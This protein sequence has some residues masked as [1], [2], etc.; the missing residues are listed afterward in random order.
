MGDSPEKPVLLPRQ[1]DIEE[2]REA[3]RETVEL[4]GLSQTKLAKGAGVVQSLVSNILG[5]GKITRETAAKLIE[6]VNELNPQYEW[7]KRPSQGP[8]GF[9]GSTT[10][11]TLRVA[12]VD[13]KFYV[14]P[15]FLTHQEIKSE[16]CPYC[17]AEMYLKC[18]TCGKLIHERLTYCPHEDC[19]APF[20]PVPDD[21]ENLPPAE[22]AR[23]CEVRNRMN[24]QLL[25]HLVEVR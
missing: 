18:P 25:R 16:Q 11:P 20:A 3:V 22:R 2:V 1:P 12:F 6:A 7:G 17:R 19:G 13:G 21:L 14:A 8:F 15:L 23:A 5:G 24:E 4:P 9:C 10:C